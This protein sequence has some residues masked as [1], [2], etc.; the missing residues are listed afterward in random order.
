MQASI[1]SGATCL[2]QHADLHSAQQG[3]GVGRRWV[4]CIHSMA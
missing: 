2:S 3:S 1:V 4:R